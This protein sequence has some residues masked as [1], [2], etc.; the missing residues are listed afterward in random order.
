VA[1]GWDT[2]KYPE[3][4]ENTAGT[5]LTAVTGLLLADQKR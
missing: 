1:S 4:A 5:G 2:I 3:V